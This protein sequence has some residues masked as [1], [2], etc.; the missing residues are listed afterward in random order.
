MCHFF[1]K[2]FSKHPE[3]DVDMWLFVGL[4][5]PGDQYRKNR[6]NIG[7]MA[8]DRLAEA[9]NSPPFKK[10]FEGLVSEKNIDNQKLILL[11]PQTYMN[12]SGRAVKAAAKFF[13]IK[14][15]RIV[16]FHDELDLAPGKLRVRL[17]GGNAGH[18]GLKSIQAHF[19]SPDFWRVR[20]GIG[21]PGD[22]NRVH[23]YVLGDFAKA[24]QD[25]V[26]AMNDAVARHFVLLL[27]GKES[28]FMSKV[29]MDMPSKA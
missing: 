2:L 9:E 16:I 6:H 4:G 7:F 14:P 3:K 28:D 27:D 11:K 25:W 15:D 29:A 26:E 17:G 12:E 13:K 24:D 20:M 10:K 22:K 8:I 21:H 1:T 19:G 18:N 23:G 5:N